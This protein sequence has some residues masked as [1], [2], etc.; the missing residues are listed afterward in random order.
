[1]VHLSHV[2][3]EAVG[4]M[5]EFWLEFAVGEVGDLVQNTFLKIGCI[6]HL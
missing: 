2:D 5:V 1:M 4:E 3:F 6:E